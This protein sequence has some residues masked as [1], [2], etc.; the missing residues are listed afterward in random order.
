MPHSMKPF[1]DKL[2]QIL[3]AKGYSPNSAL[4]KGIKEFIKKNKL[5]NSN[6]ESLEL[7]YKTIGFWCKGETKPTEERLAALIQ[8]LELDYSQ[9]N[10]L[11]GLAGCSHEIFVTHQNILTLP[12]SP[13]RKFF[14]EQLLS[15]FTVVR[16]PAPLVLLSQYDSKYIRPLVVSVAHAQYQDVY[17]ITLPECIDESSFYH[18]LGTKFGL[19]S[20]EN[21]G[22]F[23]LQFCKKFALVNRPFLCVISRFE[24]LNNEMINRQLSGVLRS[25]DEQLG[26]HFHLMLL[27]GEK[28]Q[29]LT[30]PSDISSLLNHAQTEYWQEW[31]AEELSLFCSENME[32]PELSISKQLMKLSGGHP[33][34]LEQCLTWHS[35]NKPIT[36]YVEGLSRLPFLT[37][38]FFDLMTTKDNKTSLAE[39]LKSSLIKSI[40]IRPTWMYNN[41][42]LKK[43]YW[44]NLIVLHED[45]LWWR[46]EA[47]RLAGEKVL[48]ADCATE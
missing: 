28:L 7:S 21:A 13:S 10:E 43:L 1:G 23:H 3:L 41:P 9:S 40:P 33:Q 22:Q 12:I 11:K 20:I 6:G 37:T 19:V 46:C 45:G 36:D 44:E 35:A 25:L 15:R 29:A 24:K 17:D 18:F 42:L 30:M 16:S 48:I 31:T 27:G 34:L 8:F 5:T 26:H 32:I 47:I 2:G 4:E 38:K 39:W 14:I